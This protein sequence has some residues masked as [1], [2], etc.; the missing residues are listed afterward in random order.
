MR[1]GAAAVRDPGRWERVVLA[2]VIEPLVVPGR[3]DDFHAL[4]KHLTVASIGFGAQFVVATRHNRSERLG[5]AGHGAPADAEHHASVGQDVGHRV[6]LGQAE[7]MPLGN[8]VEHLAESQAFRD[9]SQVGAEQ[10]QVRRDLVTLVLE[11]VFGEPHRVE[12][13][14][15]GFFGPVL[16]IAV[17]GDEISVGEPAVNRDGGACTGIGHR[18]AAVEVKIDA[19]G[20]LPTGLRACPS[21]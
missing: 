16:K 9:L 11:V 12:A 13:Q 8:H 19:H 18:N 20:G 1:Y 2:R 6:V 17:A 21:R 7:W 15:V 14:S 5:F 10:N 3:L 4:F